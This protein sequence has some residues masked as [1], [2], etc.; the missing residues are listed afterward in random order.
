MPQEHPYFTS[1]FLVSSRTETG[2]DGG[3]ENTHDQDPCKKE[4]FSPS[5]RAE[6]FTSGEQVI[7]QDDIDKSPD[8]VGKMG[9]QAN[10]QVLPERGGEIF[11]GDAVNKMRNGIGEE[12]TAKKNR[13]NTLTTSYCRN[14]S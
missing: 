13:S 2:K 1:V 3:Q 10:P 11:P 4:K 12:N 6:D 14:S 7:S 8:H 9:R 5:I